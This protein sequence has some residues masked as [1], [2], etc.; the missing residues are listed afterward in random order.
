MDSKTN[1]KLLYGKAYIAPSKYKAYEHWSAG[2]FGFYPNPDLKPEELESY[3]LNIKRMITKQFSVTLNS[4]WNKMKDLH[5]TTGINGWSK[6]INAGEP[7]SKGFELM[8]DYA[9]KDL[10]AYIYYSYL[11]AETD[12]GSDMNKVADNKVNAGFTYFYKKFSFSPRLRWTSDL[13]KIASTKDSSE[14]IDGSFVVDLS[15]RGNEILKNLD[16]YLNVK[17]LFDEEYYAAS[18][19]GEGADGWLMDKTPQ[20][21]IN[22][23]LGFTYKF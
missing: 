16:I 10:K 8:L 2:T 21:G 9:A 6:N 20:P 15:I 13:T 5:Q 3:S 4:Y 11:D 1:F 22:G 17:N 12:D 14:N 7:E 23:E 19:Y 18:A